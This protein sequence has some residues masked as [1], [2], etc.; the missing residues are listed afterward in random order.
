MGKQQSSNVSKVNTLTTLVHMALVFV[1]A[2]SHVASMHVGVCME[3]CPPQPLS[4]CV[5][6]VL[7][8]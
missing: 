4:T 7:C 8:H 6:G 3:V 2:C 1:H 5:F